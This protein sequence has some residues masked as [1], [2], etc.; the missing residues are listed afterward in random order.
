MTVHTGKF[1]AS[2][3]GTVSIHARVV[4]C[5]MGGTFV[6]PA[7]RSTNWYCAIVVVYTK[8]RTLADT[9]SI[10]MTSLVGYVP[11]ATSSTQDNVMPA[12]NEYSQS[13]VNIIVRVSLT[14]Q[15]TTAGSTAVVV[16]MTNDIR[17]IYARMNFTTMSSMTGLTQITASAVT[18]GKTKYLPAIAVVS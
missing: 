8:R 6:P 15:A 13:M 17:A 4:P 11:L 7:L 10:M 2:I 9:P 12:E 18:A 14:A 3:A 16:R 5:T 1:T